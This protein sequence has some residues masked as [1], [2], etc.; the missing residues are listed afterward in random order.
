MVKK[1]DRDQVLF[2]RLQKLFLGT[3]NPP[4]PCP[5]IPFQL[6]KWIEPINSLISTFYRLLINT[7]TQYHLGLVERVL[8][9]HP[10]S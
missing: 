3:R 1:A 9:V 4:P 5:H 2:E 6:C 8:K 7:Y 10:N